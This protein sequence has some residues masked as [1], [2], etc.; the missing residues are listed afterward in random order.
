MKLLPVIELGYYNQ[1]IESPI[2]KDEDS[3]I[4]DW[5]EFKVNCLKKAGMPNP[6][7]PVIPKSDFFSLQSFK[8]ENLKWLVEQHV[9][10]SIH[11]DYKGISPLFGG[12]ALYEGKELLFTPQCCGDMSD[13]HWWKHI[14][15]KKEQVFY[16]GHPSP[17]LTFSADTVSF[18]CKEEI[19]RAHV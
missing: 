9:S 5:N 13:I 18:D 16:N 15:Y 6:I 19:G 8:G 3:F 2:F 4:K 14:C 17:I 10:D 11:K 7:S 1:G 12:Y